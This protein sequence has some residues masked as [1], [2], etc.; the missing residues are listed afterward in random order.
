MKNALK[1]ISPQITVWDVG[2]TDAGEIEKQH[3]LKLCYK[4]P[5]ELIE[6]FELRIA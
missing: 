5:I 3:E 4:K 2:I 6:C 1:F